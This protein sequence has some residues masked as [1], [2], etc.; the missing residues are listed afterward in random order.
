MIFYFSATGN[1]RW[2]ATKLAATTGEQLVYIPDVMDGDCTFRLAE[3]E[4]LGFV[5]P[6]HGWRPPLLVRRFIE[7]L[8]IKTTPDNYCFALCTAGDSIARTIDILAADLAKKGLSLDAAYSLLMPEAYVGLP[9]MDVDTEEKE[10]KKKQ[11]AAEDLELYAREIA[12]RQK[13]PWQTERERLH[14][15]PVPRLLSGPV[16]GF[17]IN[18]LVTDKLFRVDQEKCL[19]CGRCASVCPVGNISGGKGKLP[20]WLHNEKAQ[21]SHTREHACMACFSCYHHCPTKAIAYGHRTK[22]KG[23]YYYKAADSPAISPSQGRESLEGK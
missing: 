14:I 2:A 22:S 1:T 13:T 17:F 10:L 7:K 21:E 5:F 9:F 6:V 8:N 4:R 23:Q 18:V 3:R 11:K 19:R 12:E 20:Q 16:G 15:G